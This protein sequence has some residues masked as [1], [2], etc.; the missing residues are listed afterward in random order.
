MREPIHLAQAIRPHRERGERA[1]AGTRR[2]SNQWLR[3]PCFMEIAATY[4][5]VTEPRVL[6]V[7]PRTSGGVVE[8]EHACPSRH[9]PSLVPG[10]NRRVQASD[11]HLCM[12]G[13]PLEGECRCADC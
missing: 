7:N 10:G 8:G 5:S 13:N 4:A 3:S 12:S 9:L 1:K 11:P 6:G 2:R